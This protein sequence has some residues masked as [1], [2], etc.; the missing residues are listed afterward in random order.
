M[1]SLDRLTNLVKAQPLQVAEGLHKKEE[2][3]QWL[4][5]AGKYGEKCEENFGYG[6]MVAQSASDM[7]DEVAAAALTALGDMGQVGCMHMH[8][9]A[10]ALSRSPKVAAAAATSLGLLGPEAAR[11]EE[12]LA[13]LMERS[14]DEAAQAAAV[15]ALGHIGA[16]SRAANISSLLDSSSAVVSGAACQALGKLPRSGMQE[17]PRIVQKLK[18]ASIRYAAVSALANLGPSI[19]EKYMSD[20]MPCL[21]DKDS[22]SRLSA[23]EALSIVP[24]AASGAAALLKHQDPGVRCTAALCLGR[25]GKE[26]ADPYVTDIASLLSDDAEDNSESYMAIGGGSHRPVPMLRRPRCA[27]LAAL[28][29]LGSDKHANDICDALMDKSHEVKLTA[30]DALM[31]LGDLGRLT[32]M[33]Q[34]ALE[35]DVYMVRVKACECLAA[36]KAEEAM[37]GL[38]ELF[39]DPAPSVRQAALQ[40]LSS[41]PEAAKNYSSEVFKCMNDEYGTVRAAAMLTLAAMGAVGQSYASA[42]AL[43]LNSQDMFVRAAACEALGKLGDHGAAFAEEV[44]LC[45]EDQVPMVRKAASQALEKMGAEALPYIENAQSLTNGGY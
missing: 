45:L 30:L 11:Y 10:K 2:L 28:G 37:T 13:N 25:L 23:A 17:A 43:E 8:T 42:I 40:A 18:V 20:I 26:A 39:E 12:D 38:P 7:D 35:D 3:L 24:A 31:Q 19:V 27:A 29:M 15:A 1:P 5:Y 22:R 33:I 16:E 9:L 14:T 4:T 44:S 6:E 21:E 32:V 41:C 36:L 34:T